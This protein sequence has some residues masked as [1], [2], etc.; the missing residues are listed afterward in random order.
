MWVW[1]FNATFDEFEPVQKDEIARN[2]QATYIILTTSQKLYVASKG[3]EKIEPITKRY[4]HNP[5]TL[6]ANQPR[7]PCIGFSSEQ[8]MPP[9]TPDECRPP[10]EATMLVAP[11]GATGADFYIQFPLQLPFFISKTP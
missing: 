11:R 6:E 1:K 9:K 2:K 7:T 8:F 4:L 5:Y 10:I 3:G